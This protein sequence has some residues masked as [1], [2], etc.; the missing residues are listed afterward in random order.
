MINEKQDYNHP[1]SKHEPIWPNFWPKFITRLKAWL[2][3]VKL[4]EDIVPNRHTWDENIK[5]SSSNISKGPRKER[6]PRAE[7]IPYSK[8]N[9]KT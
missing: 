8:L 6:N 1:S 4:L 5:F 3:P 2:L 9:S 7:L